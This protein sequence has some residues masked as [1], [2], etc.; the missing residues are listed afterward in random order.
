MSLVEIS[1]DISVTLYFAALIL[2]RSSV[3]NESNRSKAC[4]AS[5]AIYLLGAG[6]MVIH[7]LM[8]YR[9]AHDWSHEIALEHTANETERV[10]GFRLASGL[11]VNFVF[12]AVFLGDA[13]WRVC[14]GV[15]GSRRPRGVAVAIDTFLLAI[16]IMATIVF[17]AGMVRWLSVL[18]VATIT[19]R[20]VRNRS[21]VRRPTTIETR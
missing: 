19:A 17:E 11:Y 13:F 6:M 12:A 2:Q 14:V 18:A 7:I 8:A 4:R 21:T 20:A 10:V 3:T 16:V 5:N 15:P 9:L 1:A